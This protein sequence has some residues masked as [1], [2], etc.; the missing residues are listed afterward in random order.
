MLKS[1][2]VYHGCYL[3]Q[4]TRDPFSNFSR[5]LTHPIFSLFESR[6]TA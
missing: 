1:L 4:Q 2:G 6:N 3:R 5:K